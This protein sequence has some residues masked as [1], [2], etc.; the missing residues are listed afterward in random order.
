QL[1][2]VLWGESPPATA[3][4]ALHGYVS[5][6]RRVLGDGRLETRHPGYVLRVAPD[7]LDLHR[8]HALL[9]QGRHVEALALWRGPPLA[10]LAF[11]DFAQRESARLEELRLSAVEARFEHDLAGGRHAALVGELAEAVRTYPLR[12][13]LAGQLMLALYRSGRQAE[14]LDAYRDARAT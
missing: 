1:V 14:A 12:E 9:E 5:R 2:N 13:R 8:F 3:V 11:G 6:L 7:E 4:T 10:D